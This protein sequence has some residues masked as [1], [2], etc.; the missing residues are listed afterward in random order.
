MGKLN[1]AEIWYSGFLSALERHEASKPLARAAAAGTLRDWTNALTHVVVAVCEQMG[2]QTAAKGHLAE[3]LP[4]TRNEYLALDAMAFDTQ[5]QSAAWPFP[6]AVFELE[7]SRDDDKVAYSLWKLLCVRASLRVLFCYRQDVTI[8]ASLV[9][10]LANTVV[11]SLPVEYRIGLRGQTLTIVGN[12]AEESA[13]PYGFFSEW[14]LEKNTG[15][16]IRP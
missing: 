16:F 9:H 6:V 8:G 11:G 13:F 7:N 4:I 3:V 15:R 10:R 1:L 14:I 12:R 2:W 5:S